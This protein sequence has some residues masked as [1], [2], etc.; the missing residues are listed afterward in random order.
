MCSFTLASFTEG[1]D[2][3]VLDTG[4]PCKSFSL[5]ADLFQMSFKPASMKVKEC[6]TDPMLWSGAVT[7][8]LGGPA[9][10]LKH[11]PLRTDIIIIVAILAN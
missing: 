11:L 6:F 4:L 9:G 8:G 1:D 5:F 10:A 3:A 7:P 2:F